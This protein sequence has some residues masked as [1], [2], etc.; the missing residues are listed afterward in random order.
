M[1]K[2][3]IDK[4]IHS[5]RKTLTIEIAHDAALIVRAPERTS[6]DYIQ[7]LVFQ[8]RFWIQDKQRIAYEKYQQITPK[9]FVNGE[10]FL[11]LGDSYRL[12]IVDNDDM[13]LSFDKE[14]RLSKNC[15]PNARQMFIDWYK[16]EAYKK[17]KERLNWYSDLTGLK[18]SNY[19]ITN[20]QKRW[21][22]CN[23]KGNLYFSWRLIMAPLNVIDYVIVHELVHLVARNHSK[24]FW[25]K[26]RIIYPKYRESRQWLKNNEHI[27]SL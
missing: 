10:G 8:K 4:I 21:G 24:S 12:Y 25:K 17:I 6:I 23:S 3:K 7:K 15:L 5:K 2:I 22:S 19:K 18:Y 13:P 14:F 27:L 20:A 11:Y 16:Q 26:V 1:K 9:E